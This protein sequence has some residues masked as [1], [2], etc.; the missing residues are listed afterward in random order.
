MNMNSYIKKPHLARTPIDELSDTLRLVGDPT[1]L[2]VLATLYSRGSHCVSDCMCHLTGVS[3]SLL[4]HHLADLKKAGLVQSA[5][6]GKKVFY[7]ISS[8]G[9][10]L[11]TALS[12]LTK[13]DDAM[14]GCQCQGCTCQNCSC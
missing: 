8:R 10:Q 2:K 6:Q 12:K 3:Q 4:S 5:K 9:Q 11:M 14:D 13:G 1:R 7:S